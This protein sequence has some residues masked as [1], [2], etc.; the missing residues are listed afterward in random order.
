MLL[1]PG[2]VRPIHPIGL[3]VLAGCYTVAQMT[4]A[5]MDSLDAL[6]LFS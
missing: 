1:P 6:A 4:Y 2:G 3:L 5:A